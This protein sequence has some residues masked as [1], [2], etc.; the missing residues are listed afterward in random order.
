[1]EVIKG[2]NNGLSFFVI[3]NI[4][5]VSINYIIYNFSQVH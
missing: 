3:Y 1:M 5:N 2:Q 4:I